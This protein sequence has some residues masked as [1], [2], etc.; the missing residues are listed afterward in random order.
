Q[1]TKRQAAGMVS[2]GGFTANRLKV[3]LFFA[4]HK[5]FDEN[6]GMDGGGYF[7]ENKKDYGT[8]QQERFAT[9][10]QVAVCGAD[11]SHQGDF[12]NGRHGA[13]K[14]LADIKISTPR[15]QNRHQSGKCSGFEF[16]M[17]P[18]ARVPGCE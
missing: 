4:W 9:V 2:L 15:Q 5:F 11:H 14:R 12:C 10:D 3:K 18:S 8:N 6:T 7:F 16:E 17:A 13:K 1:R